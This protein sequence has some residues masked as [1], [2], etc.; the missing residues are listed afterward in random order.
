MKPGRGRLTALPEI[1]SLEEQT[2]RDNQKAALVK[3]Q[4]EEW[5]AER[6]KIKDR[7]ELLVFLKIPHDTNSIWVSADDLLNFLLDPVKFKVLA[8]KLN[9]K[10]FW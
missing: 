4:Q 7:E 2:K 9:N 5:E 10:A 6:K 3:K 8:T 1:L